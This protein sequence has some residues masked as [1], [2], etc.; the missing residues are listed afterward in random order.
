M[1]NKLYIQGNIVQDTELKV[2]DNGTVYSKNSLAVS[3]T[4]NG[5]KTTEYFDIVVFD[6]VAAS[7]T[8]KFV[9]GDNIIVEGY[10]KQDKWE[11]DGQKHS[12]V[13]AGVENI[14][15][16]FNKKDRTEKLENDSEKASFDAKDINSE[17]KKS[18][19]VKNTSEILKKEESD[20]D[21]PF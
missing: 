9:K 1:L 17:S 7:F 3:K 2:S 4:K 19:P 5:T 13:Y 21:V 11:K 16:T 6:K 18:I 15:Y 20:E 14:I 10:L 12:K 8:S